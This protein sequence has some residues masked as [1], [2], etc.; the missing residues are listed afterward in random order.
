MR[1]YRKKVFV[2]KAH[3]KRLRK[4][5]RF[6]GFKIVYS[7]DQLKNIFD[8]LLKMN[9]LRDARARISIWKEKG[10]VRLAMMV[11]GYKPPSK[12][13]YRQGFKVAVSS[14]PLKKDK[15]SYLKSVRDY[16]HLRRMLYAANRRG[17]DETILVNSQQEVREGSR[18]NIFLVK[19]GRLMTPAL[20]SGALRGIT[21][22]LVILLA[23]KNKIPC[24]EK[25]VKLADLTSADE[26]FVTS[27]LL[28]IM[29]LTKT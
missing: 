3:L 14:I 8:Q 5:L 10:A 16:V 27:S 2:L 26:A 28:E 20:T 21:R 4:G 1:V 19:Q 7:D 29:P 18:S 24:Q 17:Y 25:K 6:F 22:G 12:K 11:D 13:K 9:R 23:Q 15:P